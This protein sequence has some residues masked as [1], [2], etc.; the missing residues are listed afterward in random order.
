VELFAAVKEGLVEVQLIPKDSTLC[1]VFV[2]NKTG[3]PLNVKLPDAFAGVPV[4]AQ[5]GV[6]APGGMGGVGG[7]R[8][9]GYGGGSSYGGGMNQ[10]FGGGFGG[11]G[12][13]GF[14][15]MGG[16]GG[17]GMG[18]GFFNVP[19]ER[20]G[21]LEVKTVCL[22]HG[23]RDPRPGVKYEMKPIEEYTSK[24]AV[25]ELVRM[26]GRG[27]IDQRVAQVGA[28]HLNND[29]SWEQ[30]IAKELRFANGT[31]RPYFSPQEIQGA[32]QAVAKAVNL[33]EQRKSQ[34]PQPSTSSAS[35]NSLSQK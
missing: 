21:Q 35:S 14:G 24:P 32:M 20:V 23:K 5:A 17:M 4:L 2:K 30:L 26:L 18:G 15:G 22:D 16:M 11:M 7:R 29:M 9:G 34:Q 8:G 13:M 1:R 12:G 10:G 3:K 27:E 19:P 31:R 25:H 28:W 6:G 33:A